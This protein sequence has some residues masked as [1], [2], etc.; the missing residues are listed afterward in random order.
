MGD[1]TRQREEIYDL[2]RNQTRDLRFDRPL[3]YR[4]SHEARKEQFVPDCE[5]SCGNMNLGTNG[6]CAA[7]RLILR[8]VFKA[9]RNDVFQFN[10]HCS[11]WIGY[12]NCGR[13]KIPRRPVLDINILGK[14]LTLMA[15]Y[16]RGFC[17]WAPYKENKKLSMF[18]VKT[19][20]LFTK[21]FLF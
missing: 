9:K 19:Q 5:G 17:S 2:D 7:G 12:L 10:C 1:R 8:T 18:L 16:E 11:S 4:R 3:F 14:G 6:C 20:K 13:S 15:Q 21:V